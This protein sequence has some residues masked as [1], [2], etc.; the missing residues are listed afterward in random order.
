MLQSAVQQLELHFTEITHTHSH[1]FSTTPPHN[2]HHYML[3][4][5]EEVIELSRRASLAQHKILTINI[6]D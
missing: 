2:S 3:A 4:N 6:F 5:K 1:T